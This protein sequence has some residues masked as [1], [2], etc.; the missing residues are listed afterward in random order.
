LFCSLIVSWITHGA[1]LHEASSNF[2]SQKRPTFIIAVLQRLSTHVSTSI[3]SSLT[4]LHLLIQLFFHSQTQ[5]RRF[6]SVSF[7]ARQ[8]RTCMETQIRPTFLATISHYTTTYE[9]VKW[10]FLWPPQSRSFHF[11]MKKVP[12]LRNFVASDEN[13]VKSK[14]FFSPLSNHLD[15][16]VHKIDRI[17][18]QQCETKRE[19]IWKIHTFSLFYFAQSIQEK[20]ISNSEWVKNI[21]FTV[22]LLL[23][24]L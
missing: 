19:I 17:R 6:F 16:F 4:F 15:S 9:I 22:V 21:K 8:S 23:D 1:S 2:F 18:S 7:L 10:L 3:F 5:K 20:Y 24:Q 12:I 11:F 13:R 14:V